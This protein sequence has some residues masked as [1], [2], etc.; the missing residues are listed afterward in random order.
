[1]GNEHSILRPALFPVGSPP[2]PAEKLLWLG[3]AGSLSG[4]DGELRVWIAAPLQSPRKADC[5]LG[6]QTNQFCED[7][8]GLVSYKK[9]SAKE[10]KLGTAHRKTSREVAVTLWELEAALT[11]RQTPCLLSRR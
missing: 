7:F 6:E 8:I 11:G 4:R 3:V 1:M 10:Q 9:L 5:I 2:C